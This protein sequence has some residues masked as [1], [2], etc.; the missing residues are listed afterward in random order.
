MTAPEV[1]TRATRY[2]VTAW[3]GPVDG[4]N[5]RHYVCCMSNG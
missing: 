1:F 5:R 2:E 4:V 3:P